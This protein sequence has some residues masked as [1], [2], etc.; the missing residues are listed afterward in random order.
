MLCTESCLR[1]LYFYD[2]EIITEGVNQICIKYLLSSIFFFFF[3]KKTDWDN[4][5]VILA[6]KVQ[7]SKTE[8]KSE[9]KK[10]KKLKESEE[11]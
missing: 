9:I 8:T 1:K 4:R 6:L 10:R 7:R 5:S 11:A 2:T 3:L